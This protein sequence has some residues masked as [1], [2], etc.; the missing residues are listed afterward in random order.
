M[1]HLK[2]IITLII[3]TFTLASCSTDDAPDSVDTNLII[4]EWSMTEFTYNTETTVTFGGQ[5]INS[6]GDGEGS[7]FDYNVTFSE[8]NTLVANGSYDLT[9]TGTVNGEA[10]SAQNSTV[11]EVNTNGDWSIN[12]DQLTASGITTADID[13]EFFSGNAE[14]STSTIT[15]LNSSTLRIE[16]DFADAIPAGFEFPEGIDYNI[17]GTA[18]VTFTRVN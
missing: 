18:I 2:S 15:L 12:G 17:D 3:L 9:I 13:N 5:T 14:E 1:K 4:G 16:S 8:D 10:I 7:N 6:Q 11:S